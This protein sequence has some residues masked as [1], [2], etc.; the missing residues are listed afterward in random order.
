M[1]FS[2]CKAIC[3]MRYFNLHLISLLQSNAFTLYL[4]FKRDTISVELCRRVYIFSWFSTKI[5]SRQ[6]QANV[7]SD[8]YNGKR[9]IQC[10]K[11]RVEKQQGW[12]RTT[13]K[14]KW[15][16]EGG[17]EMVKSPVSIFNR[18]EEE[19]ETLKQRKDTAIKSIYKRR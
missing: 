17:D 5:S 19:R 10:S 12:N 8:E 14:T 7:W 11:K 4:T 16:K 15:L 2:R 1:A 18:V 13:W 3:W 9:K 6:I